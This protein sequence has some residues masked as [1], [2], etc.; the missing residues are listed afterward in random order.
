MVYVSNGNKKIGKD[1][2]I[3]NTTSATNCP[4]KKLG[5]CKI[6]KK[7]YAMKSERQYPDVLPYR[8]RQTLYWDATPVRTIEKEL[9]GIIKRKIKNKIK[10]IRFSEAGDF[11]DQYSL[12]K[13]KTLAK[14]MPE[15]IFYGYTARSDLFLLNRP[16]N[17]IING[18]S[19]M[20]D[21]SF[22]P[23]PKEDKDKYDMVCP[24]DCRDC[25]WCKEKGG[26]DIK[27]VYH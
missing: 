21:N 17:L 1:T 13:L 14:R 6:G 16:D 7:C 25:N 11:K 12:D 27:V 23:I 4:S 2:L 5:L 3:I 24:G 20:V 18:S 15:V 9:R 26:Y 8:E 22:T 19:F 10:Y